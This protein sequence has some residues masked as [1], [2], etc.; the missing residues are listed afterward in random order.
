MTQAEKKELIIK[1]YISGEIDKE[2]FD[3]LMR[4]ICK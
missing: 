4:S 2:D 3:K 1:L